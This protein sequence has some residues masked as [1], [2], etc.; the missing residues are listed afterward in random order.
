MN[1]NLVVDVDRQL[2]SGAITNLLQNALKFTRPHSLVSLVTRCTAE[3]VTISVEDQCGGL[4]AGKAEELFQ[5]FKQRSAN[6]TGIGLGLRIARGAVEANRGELRVVDLA[7]RG[8][9]F[10]IDLP[11][12][13]PAM[14]SAR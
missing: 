11:R 6:R 8:C 5:R 12:V 3:R 2:V 14:S 13:V 4:P 7:P 9:R 1:V 10:T